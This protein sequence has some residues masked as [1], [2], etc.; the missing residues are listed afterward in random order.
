MW[1]CL[2]SS[3]T[4]A[5]ASIITESQKVDVLQCPI[6]DDINVNRKARYENSARI[7]RHCLLL[8][9]LMPGACMNAVT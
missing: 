4:S 6:V 8:L 2:V 9:L 3:D 5:T 7:H 1:N